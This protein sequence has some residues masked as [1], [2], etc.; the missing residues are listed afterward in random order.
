MKKWLPIIIYGIAILFILMNKEQL[1]NWIQLR[2]STN[3]V[4]IFLI[5]TFLALFPV[6]PYGL[7]AGAL[8]AKFGYL[9][10][11]VINILASTCA[12]LIMFII[13]RN[14][15]FGSARRV[16]TRNH[17]VDRFTTMFEANAFWAVLFARLIPI[18][19]AQVVNIYS[20]ISQIKF[21][22]FTLATV[23]G[24]VPT[25]M[26]FT[27]LGDQLHTNTTNAIYTIIIY[28]LFLLLVYCINRVLRK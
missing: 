24:K 17:K 2:D 7:I 3:I 1:M 25:M 21:I 6:V 12:A 11:G 8:G 4:V 9:T 14:A 10:G 5:A 18:I 19:P 13:F 26:T 15:L 28:S 22:T 27:L 23:L 16:I 20:A